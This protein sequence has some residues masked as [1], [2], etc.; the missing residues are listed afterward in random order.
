[1]E[2]GATFSAETVVRHGRLGPMP[3]LF[4]MLVHAQNAGN[5]KAL[6]RYRPPTNL[7][8]KLQTY[9]IGY[10]YVQLQSLLEAALHP[11][12]IH[13]AIRALEISDMRC[14]LVFWQPGTIFRQCWN[15]QTGHSTAERG[16]VLQGAEQY[17]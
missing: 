2:E 16:F 3:L 14:C 13:H 4:A 12:K 17:R 7:I 9:V 10:S 11:A 1:M 15:L 8:F 6:R 5:I